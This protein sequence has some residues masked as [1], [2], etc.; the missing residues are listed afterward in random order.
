MKWILGF[1]LLIEGLE[2]LPRVPV[3]QVA[4][5]NNGFAL[6]L[7]TELIKTQGRSNLIFSP[8][9]LSASMALAYLGSKEETAKEIAEYL[10]YPLDPNYMGESFKRM[11]QDFLTDKGLGLAHSLWLQS[12]LNVKEEYLTRVN[13]YFPGR[14]HEVDFVLRSDTT[15]SEINA[16]VAERTGKKI[17]SLLNIGDMP[18]A[19]RMLLVSLV[20][21]QAAWETPFNL[22]DTLSSYF[23]IS[24]ENQRS[25]SMM[26]LQGELPYYETEEV[27]VVEIPY[28][29]LE[30]QLTR[31]GFWIVLPKGAGGL[32][33]VEA[34]LGIDKFNEWRTQATRKLLNLKVPRFRL[35]QIH[36]FKEPLEKMGLKLPFNANANFSTMSDSSQVFIHKIFQK[37]SFVIN[38]K[39]SDAPPKNTPAPRPT[40]PLTNPEGIHDFVVDKPF[41]FFVL[42]NTLGQIL[43]L[44]RIMQP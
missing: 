38:E 11:D 24:P 13:N 7:Y 10:F 4:R 43:F 22:R 20:T 21:L 12:G 3:A 26:Q 2:A 27:R 40:E 37:A 32:K 8:Y 23:F 41:L 34:S 31:L 44:G 5:S 6:A 28:Q 33:Q 15:R 42:D 16:W 1:L 14:F 39:G 17:T 29:R 25:V 19:T 30:G 35:F 36:S 9:G 18:R